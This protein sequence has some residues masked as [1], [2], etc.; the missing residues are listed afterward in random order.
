MRDLLLFEDGEELLVLLSPSERE[1][2]E[3]ERESVCKRES[4]CV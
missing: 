3:S 1:R 4:V 2:E